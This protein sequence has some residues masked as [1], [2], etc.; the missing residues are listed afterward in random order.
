M[1]QAAE[2]ARENEDLRYRLMSLSEASISINE[3]LEMDDVL[4]RVLD[5][6]RSLTGAC[7]GVM[8]T[9]NDLG[10]KRDFLTSGM[11]A[12]ER[13]RLEDAPGRQQFF[14]YSMELAQP[15]R[16]PDFRSHFR[17][18]GLSYSCPLSVRAYLSAPIR[19]REKSVGYILLGKKEKGEEFGPDDE[20]TLTMFAS[21]AAMV[22]ANARRYRDEQRARAD[23]ETLIDT[24]P[25]GVVVFD[26][27]T[28]ADVS[29][30]REMSRIFDSLRS[31]GQSD[32]E[33]LATVTCRRSDGREISL[34]DYPLSQVLCTGETMRA[35][36]VVL[37][38]SG[39]RSVGV[40]MNA[41]PI[42][43]AGGDVESIV[44]TMQDMTPLEELERMR[45]EFLA[46]VSHELRE[47]L[48]SIK[49]SITTLLDSSA[50]LNP[51]E[52]IQF[53]RII[54]SQSDRLRELMSDLLDV[55]RIEMGMLSISPEP[56]NVT[57]LIDQARGIYQS[58]TGR[59][60]V[61]IELEP[62]MP[63]VMADRLR[64]VQVLSN[65]LSNAACH[66]HESAVI[67]IDAARD[68]AFA[69]V[70]VSD[71][72]RGLSAERM[73]HLFRKFPRIEGD[74]KGH[75]KSGS[76]LGLA[77]CRGIVEAHGGR[78]WAESDGPGMGSRFTF[79]IPVAEESVDSLTSGTGGQS[80]VSERRQVNGRT[81]ILVVDDEPQTLRYVRDILTRSGYQAIVTGDPEEAL[82]I[83]VE[84]RPDI[85][86][87]DLMLPGT[88][89]IGLMKTIREASDI[90]VMFLSAYGQEQVIA[91][92]FDMGAADYVVKPFSPTELTARIRSA[93]RKREVPDTPQPY[94]HQDLAIDYRTRE[95][96]LGDRP[97]QLTA[98]EY[99]F[100]AEL[101]ANAGRVLTYEHLQRRVYGP[102]H[103]GDMRPMRTVVCNLRSKL[104]DRA[105]E[106]RFIFTEHRVGYRMP[107][108]GGSQRDEPG[109]GL[110]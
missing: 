38:V 10:Q 88:D 52:T 47:P 21:Q 94:L 42:R 109:A 23:L 103:G 16:V 64:I 30:N 44:V 107:K 46:M 40:I 101:S 31:P 50:S 105:G 54:D 24:S 84:E 9:V 61:R 75:D 89:G 95:V 60:N 25:V 77:I 90:P 102:G 1:Q 93:L 22:I 66:S 65:L 20:R 2:L 59:S 55:A 87:L 100:L 68:G 33:I 43:P 13:R 67:R 80:N 26:T 34:E 78:I 35:E 106:P 7:Y 4:Q 85:A 5:S 28:N 82:R 97:V 49:G 108:A 15:V 57:M 69:A 98:I 11:T 79:T 29:I 74:V 73:P 71:S 86:L 76:G 70:S 51:A 3:S 92:A 81:R 32:E 45:A 37:K 14:E 17:S 83:T 39:D 104:G 6:A 110:S 41:T 96:T 27:G 8:T 91:T 36:E 99:R 63:W 12:Q 58:A 72:G 48:T 19:H 62:D 53:H 18:V 56:S